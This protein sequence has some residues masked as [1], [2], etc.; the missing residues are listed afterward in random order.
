MSTKKILL[1]AS[2]ALWGASAALSQDLKPLDYAK[3]YARNHV[4]TR[5]CKE[6]KYKMKQAVDS[7]M[8]GIANFDKNGRMIHY[9]EFFAG[10]KKM[11]EYEYKY[12]DAGKMI[13]ASV[14]LVFNNWVPLDFELKYDHKGRVVSRELREQVANFWKKETYT[15]TSEVLL[16]SEQWYDINGG[17]VA[18]THKD[19]P[20]HIEVSD[21][22][23][24]Y[25]VNEKGLIILHQFISGRGQVDRALSYEYYY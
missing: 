4:T 5:V 9:T 17:L 20:P 13:K 10:G 2:I 19:Y 11:A 14:S 3:L 6:V 8:L 7:T 25:I 16:K 15:Y 18:L 12:D 22:S 21:N 1:L 23:L 24:T